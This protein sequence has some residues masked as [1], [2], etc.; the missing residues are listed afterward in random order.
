MMPHLKVYCYLVESGGRKRMPFSA[1]R[2]RL[3]L[4]IPSL[5]AIHFFL[6]SSN[7]FL[8]FLCHRI[9]AFDLSMST[10]HEKAWFPDNQNNAWIFF[11]HCSQPGTS[12]CQKSLRSGSDLWSLWFPAII[13]KNICGWLGRKCSTYQTIWHQINRLH[14]YRLHAVFSLE[15]R[16]MDLFNF[17]S[18]F[19]VLN[20]T[21]HNLESTWNW[22]F[23]VIL[24]DKSAGSPLT[25]SWRES[26]QMH[27]ATGLNTGFMSEYPNII[28][29]FTLKWDSPY[30]PESLESF[31]HMETNSDNSCV[32]ILNRPIFL[33]GFPIVKQEFFLQSVS[34]K[35]RI[36]NGGDHGNLSYYKKMLATPN[37]G[38][39]PVPATLPNSW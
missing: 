22:R 19:L 33:S 13:Q 8:W 36:Y 3:Q 12:T 23:N 31:C 7:W 11:S 29:V 21:E 4:W 15:L 27:A 28:Y 26:H 38:T 39:V 25:C 1:S 37:C 34:R 30:P 14:A 32:P 2:G 17:C 10:L 20:K 24:A 6:N 9:G 16:Y 18:I 5:G 35:A